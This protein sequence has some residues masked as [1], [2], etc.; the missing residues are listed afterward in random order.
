MKL[1]FA[2]AKILAR[3]KSKY[4]RGITSPHNFTYHPNRPTLSG[5]RPLRRHVQRLAAPG[6]GRVPGRLR[7]RRA[8]RRPVR[9][10]LP[11][12]RGLAERGGAAADAGVAR[13]PRVQ[14][15][16]RRR[17]RSRRQRRGRAR[18]AAPRLLLQ[19]RPGRGRS[20]VELMESV[21][22]VERQHHQKKK[23]KSKAGFNKAGKFS[24]SLAKRH[25]ERIG[26]LKEL[27]ESFA[28]YFSSGA[29]AEQ[30]MLSPSSSERWWL[31]PTRCR[32]SR[33]RWAATPLRWPSARRR[34]D[35]LCCWERLWARR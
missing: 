26:S 9:R 6:A 28:Y 33:G 27:Q 25:H 11:R 21:R 34:R 32:A 19:R 5:P 7:G 4:L 10:A 23:K 22:E 16:R 35:A 15:R 3:S 30:S 2:L 8:V 31:W 12:A 1:F 24:D 20:A 13:L 18:A 14:E 17:Q 29:A